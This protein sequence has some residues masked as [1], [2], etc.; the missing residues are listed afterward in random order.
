MSSNQPHTLF[1]I[2][3]SVSRALMRSNDVDSTLIHLLFF[4]IQREI[5]L[6][7]TST[8]LVCSFPLSRLLIGE[9]DLSAN[10]LN[11]SSN[12]EHFSSRRIHVH[13]RSGFSTAQPKLVGNG[14]IDVTNTR[15]GA[16]QTEMGDWNLEEDDLRRSD[17]CFTRSSRNL[18]SDG[19]D[20]F[21]IERSSRLCYRWMSTV[22]SFVNIK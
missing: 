16:R 1:F 6:I 18:E 15:V 9:H 2:R 4:F 5:E 3:I 10:R 11:T 20:Q 8:L 13:H 14:W 12:S 17:L 7:P 19:N 21:I 22:D